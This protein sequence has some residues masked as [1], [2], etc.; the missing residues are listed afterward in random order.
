MSVGKTSFIL[1]CLRMARM[2]LAIFIVT[3]TAKY[4]GVSM[5]KDM[6][7]L[8]TSF[9]TTIISAFWGPLND[10]FRTK[11]V[12]IREKDGE[13]AAKDSIQALVLSILIS[14][15]FISLVI[16]ICNKS[17]ADIVVRKSNS[18][19]IHCFIS[20]LFLLTPSIII[21]E[22]SN[23]EISI[24]N[25]YNIFYIPEVI[26]I[27][28]GIIDILAISILSP[29]TGIF[30][31]LIGYYFNI[32]AILL[33]ANYFLQKK[34]I[35][36]I[37]NGLNIKWGYTKE[38]FIFALPFF[39]PYIA[40]Q[41]NTFCEKYIAGLLGTG[42]IS[43]LDYSRQ[44]STSLQ[45][46]INTVLTTVMV[47]LLA[48]QFINNDTES[49]KRTII[50]STKICFF[51]YTI[52]AIYLIGLTDPLSQFF[53]FHGKMTYNA[54][55]IIVN[56]SRFYGI[57]FIGVLFYLL[58]GMALMAS[59]KEKHY[60]LIGVCNQLVVLVC[61]WFFVIN[62]GIYS[63]PII[64]GV[65]HLISGLIM[66]KMLQIKDKKEY[67]ALN[68]RGIANIGIFSTIYYLIYKYVFQDKSSFITLCCYTLSL[69]LTIPLLSRTMGYSLKDIIF[70]FVKKKK[71][72]KI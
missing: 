35:S 29:S 22:I 11:F 40:I 3:L 42:M 21:T 53:F 63:F 71:N 67:Y 13:D 59:G 28:S 33:A 23:I 68:I 1:F 48:K 62:K 31:L 15:T 18:N 58:N 57:A 44:F 30:A 46:V 25:A 12:F 19:A 4:F 14:A 39:L 51:I 66:M 8:V 32:I 7:V 43:T 70:S 34:S 41:L 69:A 36:I 27:I 6:W 65:C 56:L 38:Y 16:I 49:Y 72:E 50:Q 5:Q 64:F 55:H 26:A 9:L 17:I 24:L 52:A 37:S 2:V 45:G 61:N 54:L 60:A 20:L 47:P 10:I